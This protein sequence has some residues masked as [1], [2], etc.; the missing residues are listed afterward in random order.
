VNRLVVVSNR[1]SDPDGGKS[2]GGLAVGVLD[3][4]REN[5]GLWFG[6]SGEVGD[7]TEVRLQDRGK[8]QLATTDLSATEYDGYYQGFANQLLWPTLHY[9]IDLA[10][11]DAAQL[12]TY[13]E[14]NLRFARQLL[15]LLRPDDT[16]W[17][18]DYHLIPL[19][20]KLRR[21]G[22]DNRIGFFLHTPCPPAG[23]LT[24]IPGHADLLP[25]LLHCDLVGFQTE[26]DRQ[27]FV[28]YVLRCGSA[29]LDERGRLRG[30]GR[31]TQTGTYPIGVDVDDIRRIAGDHGRSTLQRVRSLSHSPWKTII[32]A[33]RLDYT[34][35]LL[36]RFAAIETLMERHAE[37]RGQVRFVQIAP[38]SRSDVWSY[39]RIRQQ[40]ET[41]TGHIN[42]R[43]ADLDWMPVHYINKHYERSALMAL[44]RHAAIGLVTPLRDGMNLVAKEYVAAQDAADPGVLV[45]SEF[46]GAARELDAALLVNPYDIAGIADALHR[47]LTMSLDERRERHR[48]M[49]ATLVRGDISAWRQRFLADLSPAEPK[50]TRRRMALA[51]S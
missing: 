47:A 25:R 30:N 1:V 29:T 51:R 2:P 13:L 32:A 24:T 39:Q 44:Y 49:L 8:I 42:G 38:P 3:A 19:A 35:G 17:I 5:G 27:A 40:L 21:L 34:K 37:H 4:L 46:A 12:A 14:V 6:W 22:V 48:S 26:D 20:A 18:H 50:S 28:D 9:R 45:L 31:G 15:P 41:L 10:R 11:Y 36:E 33:E 43:F 16:I 23:V 7:D